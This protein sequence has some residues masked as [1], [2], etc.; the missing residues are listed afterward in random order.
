MLESWIQ[1]TCDGFG[2]TESFPNPDTTRSDVRESLKT[3]GW[4]S[5]GVLDYC[6]RCVKNGN[7]RRRETDM[8]H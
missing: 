4:R 3:G 2:E 1:Y 7:A 5:H 8:N 6:P